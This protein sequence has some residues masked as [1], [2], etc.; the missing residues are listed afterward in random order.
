[1]EKAYE[2]GFGLYNLTAL[3]MLYE[4]WQELSTS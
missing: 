2:T 4:I 1:M 3:M